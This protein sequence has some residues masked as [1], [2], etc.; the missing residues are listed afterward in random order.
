MPGGRMNGWEL[1]QALKAR[2]PSLEVVLMSGYPGDIVTNHISKNT[3][4]IFIQKPFFPEKLANKLFK[5]L[6][7]KVK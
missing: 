2:R 6:D 7:G 1:A 3:G 5:I 4:V